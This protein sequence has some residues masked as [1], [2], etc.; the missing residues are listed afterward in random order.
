MALL[1]NGPEVSADG[2]ASVGSRFFEIR[3][4]LRMEQSVL[5]ERTVVQ[6]DGLEVRPLYRER[7]VPG[8]AVATPASANR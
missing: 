2:M 1:G 4:R 3:G 8:P 5:E 7:G 6:R